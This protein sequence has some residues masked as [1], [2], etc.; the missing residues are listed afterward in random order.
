MFLQIPYVHDLL[1]K[2]FSKSNNNLLKV[3]F[4]VD[5]EE[6]A[7]DQFLDEE[8]TF[9]T[10]ESQ[11]SAK[12]KVG[13][14]KKSKTI[15]K[16]KSP[17]KENSAE[18]KPRK[19]FNAREIIWLHHELENTFKIGHCWPDELQDYKEANIE[20]KGRGKPSKTKT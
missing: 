19:M 7:E 3:I 17:K 2:C 18:L 14:S 12:P 11:S 13:K 5:L 20:K 4:N 1:S 8:S 16:H 6:N 15:A 9:S 10:S